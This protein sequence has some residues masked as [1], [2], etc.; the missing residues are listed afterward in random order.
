ML[1]GLALNLYPSQM[2]IV[3]AATRET[4]TGTWVR[5]LRILLY[6]TQQEL[7]DSVGASKEDVDLL[8]NNMPIPLDIKLR[9]LKKLDAAK[10][11]A[12]YTAED[13]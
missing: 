5:T 8:E 3:F 9:I 13:I 6:L 11:A 4:S 1:V 7:A 2:T 12:R 10:S